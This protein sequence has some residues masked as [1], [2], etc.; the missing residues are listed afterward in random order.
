MESLKNIT[1]QPSSFSRH[2]CW[3]RLLADKL[4]LIPAKKAELIK[5]QIDAWLLQFLPDNFE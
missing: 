3:G 5:V 1:A 4:K 2:E